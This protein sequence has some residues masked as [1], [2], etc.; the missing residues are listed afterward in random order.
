MGGEEIEKAKLK[1]L[2]AEA[3][4]QGYL[5][6]S[7]LQTRPNDLSGYIT[8]KQQLNAQAILT[9]L[10]FLNFLACHGIITPFFQRK[11]QQTDEKVTLHQYNPIIVQCK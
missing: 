8:A 4:R 3:D 5:S 1:V 2:E 9:I 6:L 7:S 10:F 11:S